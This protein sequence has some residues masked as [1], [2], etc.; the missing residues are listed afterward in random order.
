MGLTEPVLERRRT[1]SG[2]YKMSVVE[3]REVYHAPARVHATVRPSRC[4][5]QWLDPALRKISP[6]RHS[7]S[8]VVRVRRPHDQL[9]VIAPTLV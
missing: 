8:V 3:R 2:M 9:L 7:D 6:L 4:N 1:V 5:K